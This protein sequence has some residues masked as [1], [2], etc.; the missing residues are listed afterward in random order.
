MTKPHRTTDQG[1]ITQ[2]KIEDWCTKGRTEE[3]AGR[4]DGEPEGNF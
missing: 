1:L 3:D 2:A 4:H